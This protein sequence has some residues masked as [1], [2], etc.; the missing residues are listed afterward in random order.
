MPVSNVP[1]AAAPL[2]VGVVGAGYIAGEHI[3]AY[4]DAGAEV[5]GISSRTPESAQRL[6]TKLKETIGVDIPVF[7]SCESLF[8]QSGAQAASICVIPSAHGAPEQAALKRG[9]PVMVDKPLA[10]DKET[11]AAIHD[12]VDAAGADWAVN[13]QFAAA[14]D[15]FHAA[16]AWLE[17]AEVTRAD[18]LWRDKRP[19]PAW[20]SSQT[21]SGGPT[22]EQLTHWL[23]AAQKLLGPV[24]LVRANGFHIPDAPGRPASDAVPEVTV[25]AMQFANGVEGRFFHNCTLKPDET[26]EVGLRMWT[27]NGEM[28]ELT[29]QAFTVTRDGEVIHQVQNAENPL[30]SHI[31]EFVGGVQNGD[32]QERVRQ[33]RLSSYADAYE[34][35]KLTQAANESMRLG[36]DWLDPQVAG[37][38]FST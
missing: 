9:I 23:N 7:D 10:H 15:A 26:P 32:F 2:K 21:E 12:A 14:G 20:W 13:Y 33:G 30:F 22:H 37:R 34:T 6:A 24:E 36:G 8:E 17:T 27:K 25:G 29:R 4:V 18:A 11:S 38:P 3:K 28:L 1:P 5:V 19:P 16:K 35:D 31:R